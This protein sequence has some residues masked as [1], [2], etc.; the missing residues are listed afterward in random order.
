MPRKRQG[1]ALPMIKF[2]EILRLHELGL[3][4]SEIARSCLLSRSTVRDY[5]QRATRQSLHYDQLEQLSDSEIKQ[6]LGK[7]R[8]PSKEESSLD[9]EEIHREVQQKGVTLSLIWMEL[10]ERGECNYSYSGFCRRY[11]QWRERQNLSMR[12][13]YKGG[14]NYRA[15]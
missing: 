15:S 14:D 3:N 1:A 10:K 7:G 2:R 13:V 8:K 6:L 11:R 12:Q 4:T 5:V 9:Y